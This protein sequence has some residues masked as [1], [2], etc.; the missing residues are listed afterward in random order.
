MESPRTYLR[1]SRFQGFALLI[2]HLRRSLVGLIKRLLYAR[3]RPGQALRTVLVF[4]T[5]RLGDFLNAV[6]ALELL[7]SRLPQA[8]IIFATTVSSLPAMQSITSSY[9]DLNALPWLEFVTPSLVDRAVSFTMTGPGK[10][11]A[12][13]RR[14]IAAERP[15]AIF[16]L[17]YMGESLGGKLRKLLF[18]RLAGFKGPIF[19]FEGFAS[20]AGFARSQY[21]LG[22]YEHEVYGPV[23]A[24]SECAAI[25]EVA[26]SEMIQELTIPGPAMHWAR[27]M[28]QRSG[29]TDCMVVAVSP[30]ATFIHKV[31]PTDRYVRLCR[32]LLVGY[33]CRLVVV[34][35]DADRPLGEALREALGARCLDL[36][37]QTSVTQLAALFRLCRLFVGNDGGPAHLASA[38]GCPCVTVT[39]ALD[40]PGIWEPWNSRERVAR[41]RI[42]CEFC[43]SLTCC[44]RKTNACITAVDPH[45]VLRMCSQ[46]L[47]SAMQ[48]RSNPE[49]VAD[50]CPDRTSW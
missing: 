9:A 17:P 4:R 15:D 26:E 49:A 37:G 45:E 20:R 40:F 36:T 42:D 47:G 24:V 14:T 25:G 43:L 29:F 44:P 50:G 27:N 35:I 46:V 32:E 23:R 2:L 5:G 34:G 11:L 1:H 28:L 7:R 3:F 31:W 10:G 21:R 38:A 33:D 30:G 39:S 22:L 6:P 12:P 41:V 16:V 48:N 13:M 18:F 8:R 19:G